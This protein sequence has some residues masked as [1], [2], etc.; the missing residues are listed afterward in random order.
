[1]KVTNSIDAYQSLLDRSSLGNFFQSPIFYG[2][3]REIGWKPLVLTAME[4]NVCIGGA[5]VYIPQRIRFSKSFSPMAVVRM[6]P[7][8]QNPEALDVLLDSFEREIKKLGAIKTDIIAPFP[9]HHQV[10]SRKDYVV[11]R[12]GGEYSVKINL[13]NSTEKLWSDIKKGCRKRI[14]K[15][16]KMGTK[17]KDVESEEELKEFYKIYLG[18]SK[19]RGFFPYPY[20]LFKELW[21]YSLKNKIT[22]F[23]IAVHK[24]KI[25]AGKI[26]I[27]YF[28]KVTSFISCSIKPSWNL[29]PN[30]L[31]MWSSITRSKEEKAKFFDI[32]YL[33]NKKEAN[34]KIDYYTF[35]TSFG[36]KI[37]R[38][39]IFYYKTFCPL[40]CHAHG[41]ITKLLEPI[42]HNPRLSALFAD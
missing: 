3:L 30:H 13:N 41:V 23:L 22:Q 4:E 28:G 10:F 15:T 40:R 25:I 11:Q 24:R 37:V 42:F 19:R 33:P 9:C 34:R 12:K 36:G 29:N 1:M 21:K 2:I 7:I 38:T 8:V 5:L 17:V 32:W 27:Q 31:L 20:R 18:T 14:K 39:N 16:L 26:N 6:G 35:K